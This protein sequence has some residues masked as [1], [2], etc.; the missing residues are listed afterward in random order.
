MRRTGTRWSAARQWVG[1]EWAEV[2][3]SVRSA[4]EEAGPERDTL[5]QSLKA[6]G[7]AILAWALCGWWFEAPMALLA[8]WT[9][10]AMVGSTVYQSLRTGAQQLAIIALGAVWASGA[11]A[12]TRDRSMTS[13]LL[14]LPFMMLLGNYRRF[15]AQGIYGATTALFVI[16]AGVSSTS[17]VGHRLLE[18]LIGAV[19]GL[20]VNALVLPP[21]HLRSVRDRLGRV[22]QETADLLNAMADGL[23]EE[24]GLAGAE[25][26]HLR[27]TRLTVSLQDVSDARRWATEGS[28][29]NPGSRLRRTGPTPPPF[30]DDMRW[31]RVCTRALAVARTLAGIREDPELS[32]PSPDFFRQLSDV[33]GQ[34]AVICVRETELLTSAE[35][36][37]PRDGRDAVAGEARAGLDALT[38]VFRR[39]EGTAAAV[40]GELLLEVRQ[41][42]TELD[43]A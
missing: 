37:T 32:R 24:D 25:G 22:A 27:A 29:W 42:V 31:G 41:L 4:C 12:L 11:M 35:P 5:V 18:T 7:A 6:A 43:S 1:Q 17:T 9:A 10:I 23:R 28:R 3:R 39:Q 33:L 15:G 20:L 13:M 14:T 2:R 26:W 21:V 36:D 30:A 16:T 40:G 19:I 38:E 34:A 8:P